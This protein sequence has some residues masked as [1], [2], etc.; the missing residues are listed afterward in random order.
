M[1]RLSSKKTIYIYMGGALLL[2]AASLLLLL[3]I[4]NNP[5]EALK[6]GADRVL[7]DGSG[8]EISRFEAE[9]TYIIG[10]YTAQVGSEGVT[11]MS[12]NGDE[13]YHYET[14]FS[15][16]V[17][18]Q[19]TT[20]LVI[21]AARG[22]RLF[23]LDINANSYRLTL[24]GE[25]VSVLANDDELLA[26]VTR[27]SGASVLTKTTL[28][29]DETVELSVFPEHVVPMRMRYTPD[30]RQIDV[31]VMNAFEA[32]P[33]VSLLRLDLQGETVGQFTLNTTEWFYDFLYLPTGDVWLS[34][35]SSLILIDSDLQ[36]VRR[37]VELPP[38]LGV[39]QAAGRLLAL[40]GDEN[41]GYALYA[42]GESLEKTLTFD[43]KPSVMP[44][45]SDTYAVMVSDQLMQ[46]VDVRGGRLIADEV[47]AAP[48]YRVQF[49]G[50]TTF[51]VISEN[52]VFPYAI[53]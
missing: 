4:R 15:E 7:Q 37:E 47:L 44:A 30:G 8:Y 9:K 36:S 39:F 22:E 50:P 2:M 25:V 38:V 5:A 10:D 52:G 21:G 46:V 28:Q 18:W 20:M 13:R 35:Q 17:V 14:E 6:L 23:V 33:N 29:T 11:L 26:L 12:A 45:V 48:L 31:L 41:S 3:W 53:H 43:Q 27:A 1:N 49:T 16:P 19:D 24:P 32:E 42:V 34:A 40:A 51:M